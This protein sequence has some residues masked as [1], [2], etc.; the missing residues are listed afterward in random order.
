M[1]RIGAAGLAGC[2]VLTWAAPALAAARQPF[3]SLERW[4]AHQR[5]ISGFHRVPGD[6]G[7]GELYACRYGGYETIVRVYLVRDRITAEHIEVELPSDRPDA[8][9]LGIISHFFYE[10][11]GE[12]T[13]V[14]TLWDLA[15]NLRLELARSGLKQVSGRYRGYEL[16]LHLDT[17][18]DNS[19]MSEEQQ[20]WGTL[21]WRGD[22]SLPEQA[23]SRP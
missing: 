2:A 16:G 3:S 11:L 13:S 9:A 10:F 20:T 8:V 1:T 15:N 5:L 14:R 21:F 22:V 18:P 12:R 6:G 23:P 7:G 17:S 19:Y 4:V